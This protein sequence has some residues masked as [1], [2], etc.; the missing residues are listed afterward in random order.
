MATKKKKAPEPV[1]ENKSKAYVFG[2]G[3]KAQRSKELAL[4]ILAT[5]SNYS[6]AAKKIGISEDQLYLWLRED[7]EF[8]A[9]VDKMRSELCERVF[10]EAIETLKNSMTKAVTTLVALLDRHD[11]PA[12]QRAAANDILTHVQ[13]FKELQDFEERILKLE[14]RAAA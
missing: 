10:K 5:M 4:P 3:D 7:P 14:A 9:Q 1:K 8:K 13:K 6:E 11:Y 2:G 12:V